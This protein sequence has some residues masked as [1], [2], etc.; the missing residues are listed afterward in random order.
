MTFKEINYLRLDEYIESA[1]VD[2]EELESYYDPNLEKRS[3]RE[4]V[5][6]TSK[7]IKQH[8]YYNDKLQIFGID[9]N[10]K[11]CGFVVFCSLKNMLYSFGINK[12]MRTAENLNYLFNFFVK[13]MNGNFYTLLYEKNE[14]AVNWLKKCGMIHIKGLEPVEGVVYLS[15]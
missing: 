1:W 9:E 12:Q 15:Y 13:K 5:F 3:L 14:R 7:K 10:F 11:P 8:Y 4:M 2:D 6:D